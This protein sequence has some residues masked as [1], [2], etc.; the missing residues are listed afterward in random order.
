[1]RLAAAWALALA[2]AVSARAGASAAVPSRAPDKGC[3]WGRLSDPALGLEL[4]APKCD[5]GF[6]TIAFDSSAK[7]GA[8]YQ[9]WRDSGAAETAE[10]VIWVYEAKGGESVPKALAR[11]F[12]AKLAP[13]RRRHCLV[14]EKRLPFLDG[15][16]KRAYEIVPDA[17]LAAKT[18][19]ESRGDVPEPPCGDRGE[20]ADGVSYFE[21]HPGEN[22][23][24]F[25]FVDAGQEEHPLFDE[26]SIS[27]LP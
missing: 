9:V 3:A 24:R 11:L 6:R 21:Y 1:M 18:D 12:V 8:V 2:A 20:S 14:R 19:E 16:S 13:E 23:R 10:A 4:F 26:K 5:F 15:V 7:K 25:A 17:E 27:F 22:P